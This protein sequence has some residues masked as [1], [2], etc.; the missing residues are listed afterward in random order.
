M[1]TSITPSEQPRILR[2]EGVRNLH[3]DCGPT[4]EQTMEMT[5]ALV[6]FVLRV[7]KGKGSPEEVE[8]LPEIVKEVY[9]YH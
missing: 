1:I 6:D 5:E 9:R 3:K 8:I 4:D 2:R 7:S